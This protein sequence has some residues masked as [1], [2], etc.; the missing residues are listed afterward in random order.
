MKLLNRYHV[1]PAYLFASLLL[2][3]AT[4]IS[5]KKDGLP[6][7]PLDV[8]PGTMS[9]KVDGT[10]REAESAFVLALPDEESGRHIVTVTA[11]FTPE[12]LTSNDEVTD[13]FNIY[14]N[15]SAAQFKNPKGTY[16]L[17]YVDENDEHSG[18]YALYQLKM[19][20]DD[21]YQVYGMT[22]PE[23]TAGKLTITDFEIG[24]GL[25]GI[26]GVPN[27]TGYSKLQGTFQ[28]ELMGATVPEHGKTVKI[29]EGK[30]NVRNQF[31]LR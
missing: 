26:P 16:D 27:V 3:A 5:C 30:F 31:G 17:L 15:L 10:M 9:M 7:G 4:A 12:G 1:K 19:G 23:N 8:S 28:M 24:S 21:G 25:S 13:A 20:S 29:T 2:L 11:F 14:L 6:G 18:F 22:D